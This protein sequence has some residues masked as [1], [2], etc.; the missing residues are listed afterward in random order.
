[1]K[2]ETSSRTYETRKSHHVSAI[3]TPIL[4]RIVFRLRLNVQLCV[5]TASLCAK[6]IQGNACLY[7]KAAMTYRVHYK[8]RQVKLK[9]L[10]LL[11]D[12][13]HSILMCTHDKTAD[14]SS[15]A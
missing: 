9:N 11:H 2:Q 13:D 10:L 3:V 4:R 15:R 1:M 5:V 14:C 8:H 7:N 12:Q 6:K